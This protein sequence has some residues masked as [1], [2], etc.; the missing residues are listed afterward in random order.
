MIFKRFFGTPNDRKVKAFQARVAKINAFEPRIEALSDA[1]LRG[2]TDEF[3]ARLA[4]GETLDQ[5]CEEAFAVVREGARRAI[6]LRHFDVQMVGGLALHQGGRLA[7][8]EPL[9]RRA[10]AA[11]T[12][13]FQAQFMF[14]VLLYQL[15]KFDEAVTAVGKALQRDELIDEACFALQDLRCYWVEHA[16]R[17]APRAPVRA[18]WPGR[19]PCGRCRVA[20]RGHQRAGR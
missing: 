15:Q 4:K 12:G 10:L 7:E 17:H 6:G 19:P 13:D 20:A 18:W 14:A 2:K 1:E 3:K 8:A 5:I 16:P 9:Y 11:G